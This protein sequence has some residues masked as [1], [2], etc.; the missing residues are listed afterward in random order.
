MLLCAL[1]YKDIMKCPSTQVISSLWLMRMLWLL[2]KS[3]LQCR[4]CYTFS[5]C[6]NEFIR[7]ASSFLRVIDRSPAPF[8]QPLS[9]SPPPSPPEIFAR[10]STKLKNS[11]FMSPPPSSFSLTN[12]A[13]R[14]TMARENSPRIQRKWNKK[15][16]S[17]FPAEFCEIRCCQSHRCNSNQAHRLPRKCSWRRNYLRRNL[18]PFPDDWRTDWRGPVKVRVQD[19]C[20]TQFHRTL[21]I[22]P[23]GPL[24]FTRFFPKSSSLKILNCK[25]AR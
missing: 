15:L 22:K 21:Q 4:V 7:A 20:C 25:I 23:L 11:S 10:W 16:S 5:R 1:H 24:K 14:S 12:L 6:L 9:S 19:Q 8:I 3:L 13:S 18:H 17:L 2:A